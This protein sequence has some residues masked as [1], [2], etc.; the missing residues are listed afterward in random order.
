MSR[1]HA[2]LSQEQLT[3]KWVWVLVLFLWALFISGTFSDFTRS[4]GVIQSASLHSLLRSRML[5]LSALEG[6]IAKLD[7]ERQSLE[8]NS[9][10]QEREVRKVLGYVA[11][12][13]LIFEFVTADAS[14]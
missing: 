7:S 14:H 13:E 2:P 6:K 1:A 5:E 3:V 12:N 11:P 8:E 10:V 4:P 9:V